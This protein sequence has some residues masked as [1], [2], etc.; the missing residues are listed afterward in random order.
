MGLLFLLDEDARQSAARP[1]LGEF[2]RS[3]LVAEGRQRKLAVRRVDD[4]DEVRTYVID[5]ESSRS[6]QRELRT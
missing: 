3:G 5:C 6:D 4:E 1:V 2:V